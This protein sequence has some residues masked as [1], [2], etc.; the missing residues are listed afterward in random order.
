[1]S[2]NGSG[3]YNLPTGNPVVTGTT[4]TSNWANTTLS[5][6]STALTGS[7]ASDGQ[8]PVTGD[9]QMGG[10]KVTGMGT[11]TSAQDATTKAYVDAGV[12]ALGTM[13]TQNSNNVAITGGSI[14]G[15]TISALA[16]DLPV[17]SGGTG[18]TTSTGSGANV[19]GTSPTIATPTISGLVVTSMGSSVITSGT[20]V[21][22]TSGTSIDFTGIPSWAKRITIM[23]NGVSTSG[24]SMPAMQI[25]AGSVDT[26]GYTSTVTY[27]G[28]VSGATAATTYFLLRSGTVNAA[29]TTNGIVTLCLL[30]PNTWV[31]SIVG[32]ISS[33][34][35]F[36]SQGGGIKTLSGALDR[37]R[38]TTANGTDTFDAGSINILYE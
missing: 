9:I 32:F 10:N 21:A 37:V 26:S 27:T 31:Q 1:M 2:R 17:A 18:V 25:G 30:G 6:I 38:I 22:S 24:T 13:A 29:D 28:S 35:N 11:P 15:V 34:G 4:I 14:T 5:D 23:L 7:L 19:L 8:T 20:A 36:S 12:A 3:I 16:S 33:A